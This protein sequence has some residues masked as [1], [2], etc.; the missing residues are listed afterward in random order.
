M[1]DRDSG[2]EAFRELASRAIDC[3][4]T[5]AERLRFF[6]IL[7]D[8]E[9]ARAEFQRLLAM[10]ED[11]EVLADSL[12][13]AAPGAGFDERLKRTLGGEPAGAET[14]PGAGAAETRLRIDPIAHGHATDVMDWDHA[15]VLQPGETSQIRVQKGH[16]NAYH[17]RFQSDLP[18]DVEI[19]HLHARHARAISA[20]RTRVHG[21]H[22]AALNRPVTDDIIEIRNVGAHPVTIELSLPER[23][24]VH[25]VHSAA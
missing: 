8:Q 23:D 3:E 16:A 11:L 14:Q 22:Y 4:L 25:I 24:S 9:P 10:E 12:A 5:R 7:L 20:A 21:A 2:M 1:Q 6:R 19:R 13:G 17:F 18:V 15:H